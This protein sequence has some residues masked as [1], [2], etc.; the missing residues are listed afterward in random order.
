MVV[1]TERCRVE[2]G[3]REFEYVYKLTENN[4][5][6]NGDCGCKTLVVYGVE[7]Q[8]YEK[9]ND[10]FNL[11]GSEAVRYLSPSKTRVKDFVEMLKSNTVSPVHLLDITEEVI[12]DFYNDF[13][14]VYN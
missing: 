8:S 7:I 12:E 6:V 13:D 5:S 14:K 4:L 3:E 11:L 2:E 10:E 1:S 9:N